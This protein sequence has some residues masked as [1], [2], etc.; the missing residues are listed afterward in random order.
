MIYFFPFKDE[1]V[2][3]PS[4]FL[5]QRYTRRR[6]EHYF[7]EN[8]N[9][10][11]DAKETN[12]TKIEDDQTIPANEVHPELPSRRRTTSGSSLSSS[13]YKL[14]PPITNTNAVRSKKLKIFY[15]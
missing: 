13:S 15:N 2:S 4:A 6:Q 1:S 9:K 3:V 8:E 7:D 12:K 10:S 14:L 5:K 11:K